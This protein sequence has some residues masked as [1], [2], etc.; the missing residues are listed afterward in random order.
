MV[1]TKPPFFIVKLN[2]LKMK[3]KKFN[4]IWILINAALFGY[5]FFLILSGGLFDKLTSV[6]SVLFFLSV[7]IQ[8]YLKYANIIIGRNKH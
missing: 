1:V 8:L 4:L 3:N 2:V 5:V 6:L 7:T